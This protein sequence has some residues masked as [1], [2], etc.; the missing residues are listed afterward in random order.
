MAIVECQGNSCRFLM[1]LHQW[2]G[3][4]PVAGLT[5][6]GATIAVDQRQASTTGERSVPML[7]S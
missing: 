6:K 3:N 5:D 4:N 2:T 7:P 1:L